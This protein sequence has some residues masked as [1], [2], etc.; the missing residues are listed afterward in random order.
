MLG[1]RRGCLKSHRQNDRVIQSSSY[2]VICGI[3][4]EGGGC[5]RG[6]G[7]RAFRSQL[8]PGVMDQA[9]GLQG[10]SGD[11]SDRRSPQESAAEV[12][13]GNLFLPAKRLLNG[14]KSSILSLALPTDHSTFMINQPWIPRAEAREGKGYLCLAI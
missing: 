4:E 13:E 9:S 2:R 7:G 10:T 8:L 1:A 5:R 6:S 3:R 12:R 14:L 11:R